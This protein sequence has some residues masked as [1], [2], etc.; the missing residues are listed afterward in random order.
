MTFK[1]DTGFQKK[2]QQLVALAAKGL[3]ALVTFGGGKVATTI[4][5]H[6]E[7]LRQIREK[8]QEAKAKANKVRN[9]I[10]S[11]AGRK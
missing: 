8:V 2:V 11:L 5:D 3:F 1:N 7:K 4:I 6:I 10:N 9:K